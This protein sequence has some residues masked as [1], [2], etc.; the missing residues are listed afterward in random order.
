M[1]GWT[2]YYPL[3]GLTPLSTDVK[4]YRDTEEVYAIPEEDI[5][6]IEI[7]RVL[8]PDGTV[9][10]KG[11]CDWPSPV[12]CFDNEEEKNI[13]MACYNVTLFFSHCE[14]EIDGIMIHSLCFDLLKKVLFY[15]FNP[16]PHD[17]PHLTL[18]QVYNWFSGN[19]DDTTL[20]LK[21]YD[22]GLVS[23]SQGKSYELYKGEE[24]VTKR[25]DLLANKKNHDHQRKKMS[26]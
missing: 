3:C 11:T 22:Y 20:Y 16:S 25:P 17:S 12:T 24:W 21:H 15:R 19:L 7:V 5:E 10:S 13:I 6:F 9:S 2:V 4:H 1:G 14:E 8:L 26:N 23:D 18:E